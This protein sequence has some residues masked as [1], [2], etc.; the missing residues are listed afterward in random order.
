ME[1]Q[2]TI[3]NVTG[4]LMIAT[5]AA[6]DGLQLLFTI[7]IF[8]LPLSWFVSFL[9]FVTFPLWFVLAAPSVK[10]A[11]GAAGRRL[12]I[13]LATAVAELAPFINGL[14]A[15]TAGVV[16]TILM[17]RFE[18]ARRNAGG[19]VTPRTSLATARA[20]RVQQAR[21]AREARQREAREAAETARYAAANDNTPSGERDAA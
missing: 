3:G 11:G 1:K 17:T 6:M 19:R 12:L 16:G 4:G 8:L 14:P 15:L 7:S 21:R 20:M 18:D 13:M 10:Y 2:R 9:A 5:A